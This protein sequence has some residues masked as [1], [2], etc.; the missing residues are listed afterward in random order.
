MNVIP[1]FI[2]RL[3]RQYISVYW[4]CW[5][6]PRALGFGSVANHKTFHTRHL[7]KLYLYIKGYLTC[8]NIVVFVYYG[9]GDSHDS[10][11]QREAL[12]EVWSCWTVF[13]FMTYISIH[14]WIIYIHPRFLGMCESA[15][16]GLSCIWV[17]IQ[18][19]WGLIPITLS[20]IKSFISS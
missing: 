12:H 16:K 10:V 15:L 13:T 8:D 18:Q 17:Q 19:H 20:T 9:I 1:Q 7:I 6:G 14:F 3:K 4:V 11:L 5:S 2:K